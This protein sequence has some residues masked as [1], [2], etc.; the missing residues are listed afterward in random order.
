MCKSDRS[1]QGNFSTSYIHTFK[2]VDFLHLRTMKM[3]NDYRLSN[4][5]TILGG[6]KFA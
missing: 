2:E 3:Y 1:N 6:G 5:I 4:I